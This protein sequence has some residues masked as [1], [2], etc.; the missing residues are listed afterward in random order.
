MDRIEAMLKGIRPEFDFAA[1]SDFIA[2]GL[3]DSFDMVTLVADLDKTFSISIDGVEIVP[4]NFKNIE[5][6]R[7]LL[8]KHGITT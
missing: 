2:D 8:Q 5:T 6:I 1:S 7:A 4:E 3:L